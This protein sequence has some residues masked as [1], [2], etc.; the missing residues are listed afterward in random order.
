MVKE[1]IFDGRLKTPFL[2]FAEQCNEYGI[3]WTNFQSPEETIVFG[4]AMSEAVN[5]VRQLNQKD[6]SS[7]ENHIDVLD[8]GCGNSVPSLFAAQ[9]LTNGIS[10]TGI[11]ACEIA[12]KAS[13]F[14]ANQ[15][16]FHSE[17]VTSIDTSD[18]SHGFRLQLADITT[19][20]LQAQLRKNERFDI[21]G[22]NLPYLPNDIPGQ[23]LDMATS[24]G[25]DGLRF[26]PL[27]TLEIARMVKAS[28]AVVTFSSLANTKDSFSLIFE[29]PMFGI[30]S[31]FVVCCPLG[32]YTR[33][34]E[35]HIRNNWNPLLAFHEGTTYQ[36]I[37]SV[38][39]GPKAESALLSEDDLLIIKDFENI[40]IR[41]VNSIPKATKVFVIEPE[42][43]WA[44]QRI[45][46]QN[47]QK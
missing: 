47:I 40:G 21:V 37:F 29:D 25:K 46:I 31:I 3:R 13:F 41:V 11:D 6:I 33:T 44:L 42:E 43:Y 5:R 24:G 10:I 26:T 12:I 20:V 36:L 30:Q 7:V 18:K 39:L 27:L 38:V 2:G 17:V 28:H 35:I 9:P 32:N 45:T 1:L 14:N 34:H 15:I 16:G 23:Q 4:L 8:L 22:G 19:S